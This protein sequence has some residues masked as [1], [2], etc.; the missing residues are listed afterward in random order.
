MTVTVA[1]SSV[2]PERVG[3]TAA[4]EPSAGDAMAGGRATVSFTTL[5]LA[6]PVPAGL[7]CVAVTVTLGP[8]ASRWTSSVAVKALPVHVAEPATVPTVTVTGPASVLHAPVTG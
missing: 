1:K 5:R 4:S 2:F 3:L 7:D 6:E 8:S